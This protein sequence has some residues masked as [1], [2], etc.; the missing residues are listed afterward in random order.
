MSD[1]IAGNAALNQ[2]TLIYLVPYSLVT[3]SI[4]TAIFTR[5]SQ[6]FADRKPAEAIA[7]YTSGLCSTAIFSLFAS[8]LFG[9]L[10]LALTK[11]LIPSLEIYAIGVVGWI[12]RFQALGYLGLSITL[13]SKR[14][15][16]AYRAPRW[17]FLLNLPITFLQ[18]GGVWLISWWV[19]NQ[20]VAE[21]L[22]LWLAISYG[23]ASAIYLFDI[24]RRFPQQLNLLRIFC[25]MVKSGLGFL[26]TGGFGLLLTWVWPI[27]VSGNYFVV[28]GQTVVVA[29]LMA[30]VYYGVLRITKVDHL[31]Y[32][33]NHLLRPL[34]LIKERFSDFG[35][36]VE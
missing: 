11:L 12:V 24:N 3:V 30:I 32:Y 20:H 34:R 27:E 18:M 35:G 36:G 21:W 7:A 19:G 2:A 13:L 28:A 25:T 33:L 26:V 5:M 31:N 22:V 29:V 23:I 15:Y 17:A 16:F 6:A 10:G 1:L 14:F 4:A 9:V 8:A